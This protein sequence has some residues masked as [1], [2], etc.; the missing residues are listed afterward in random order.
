MTD[1]FIKMTLLSKFLEIKFHLET[2]L[3]D[4]LFKLDVLLTQ[5]EFSTLSQALSYAIRF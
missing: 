3:T 1:N 2:R 4:K 5:S